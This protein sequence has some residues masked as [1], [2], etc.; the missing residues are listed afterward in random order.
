[1][2][3]IAT[4]GVSPRLRDQIPI[5]NRN[6]ERAGARLRHLIT[7]KSFAEFSGVLEAGGEIR[8]SLQALPDGFDSGFAVSFARQEAAEHGD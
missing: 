8:H 5:L 7:H 6:S 4:Y 3:R 2:S 1:M